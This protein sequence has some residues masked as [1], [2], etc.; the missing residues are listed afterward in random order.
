L[1]KAEDKPGDH[2]P[3]CESLLA[4][5]TPSARRI[6]NSLEQVDAQLNAVEAQ[7]PRLQKYI[8]ELEAKRLSLETD[9]VDAQSALSRAIAEDERAKGQQDMLLER[10]RV[11]GRIGSFIDGIRPSEDEVD[12]TPQ[13]EAAKRRLALETSGFLCIAPDAFFRR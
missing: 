3:V 11:V 4:L 10:A 13:I 1:F 7:Q 2:C 12:L 5:P 9:L 6:I 8:E